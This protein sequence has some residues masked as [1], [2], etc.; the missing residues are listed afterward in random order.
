M[1]MTLKRL[2]NLRESTY[3]IYTKALSFINKICSQTDTKSANNVIN[4]KFY[5]TVCITVVSN[6]VV[7]F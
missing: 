5:V 7:Y 4:T 2:T 6:F 3:L 1:Q